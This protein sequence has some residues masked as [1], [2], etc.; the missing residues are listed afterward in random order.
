MVERSVANRRRLGKVATYTGGFVIAGAA[1]LGLASC[2]DSDSSLQSTSTSL[3]ETTVPVASPTREQT[4]ATNVP[5]L[6]PTAERTPQLVPTSIITSTIPPGIHRA[7][8]LDG[9]ADGLRIEDAEALKL[10]GPFTIEARVKLKRGVL[11]LGNAIISKKDAYEFFASTLVTD[12][13]DLG[14]AARINND[15]ICAGFKISEE[16]YVHL[17]VTY[18]RQRVVFYI[19]G[20]EVSSRAKTGSVNIN[21]EALF[22]GRTDTGPLTKAF[23]GEKDYVLVFNRARSVEQIAQDARSLEFDIDQLERQGM[24]LY[25][26]FD[27]DF[28]DVSSNKY[29]AT[30]LGE[31]KLVEVK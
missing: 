11:S 19:D 12:C 1:S 31:P 4:L 8:A 14:L 30:T 7:L 20:K 3:V 9:F 13:R 5:T 28:N 26:P 23:G 16:Q 2:G 27:N 29:K 25:L 18:D 22:V 21:R 6:F 10:T 17:A 24:V 15:I